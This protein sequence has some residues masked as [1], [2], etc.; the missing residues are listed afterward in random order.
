MEEPAGAS[1]MVYTTRERRWPSTARIFVPPAPHAERGELREVR[2][3]SLPS[4]SAGRLYYN[5][6]DIREKGTEV[7]AGTKYTPDGSPNLSDL[8]FLPK[9]GFTGSVQ[10]GYEGTDSRGKTFRGQ[11]RIQVDQGSGSRYFQDMGGYAWAAPCADLLYEAG[12]VTG[13]GSQR[14]RPA[15]AVSRGDFMLMLYQAF[16]LPTAGGGLPMFH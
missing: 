12:V 4:G 2:F 6:Q 16:Q 3:T 13:T 14:Y 8:T 15:D 9:A 7:R 10:I 1:E 11:I 5:Y